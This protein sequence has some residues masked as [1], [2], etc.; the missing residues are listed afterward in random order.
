MGQVYTSALC[1]FGEIDLC[2]LR[3]KQPKAD[4]SW[5]P[6]LWLGRDTSADRHIV[7]TTSGMFKTRSIR[8]LPVSEQVDKQF[9]K[10][11]QA[12]HWDPKGRGED[13]DVLVLPP[14]STFTDK[15]GSP[16]LPVQQT[17]GTSAVDSS[18]HGVKR[19]SDEL[20]GEA[21]EDE[22]PNL[23]QR[24]G[25]AQSDLKRSA[26]DSVP[27]SE[28]K[29]QRISAV[30]EDDSLPV[31]CA[32]VASVSTKSGLDVPIEPNV[33]REEELQA[34]RAAE[35]VL[36]YDTEFDREQAARDCRNEQGDD[37]H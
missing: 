16:S 34:L 14:S 2:R 1:K 37:F 10:D 12:K 25:P 26:P 13:T 27:G 3:G 33:D 29:L 31:A 5:V 22:P 19:T 6:G 18:Q 17:D 15:Q 9:L 11:F 28:T 36:W 7:A 21:L 23:F 4:P 20:G 24:V 35:P 30:F 32:C 8:R